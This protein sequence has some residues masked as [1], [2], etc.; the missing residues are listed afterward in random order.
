MRR[1]IRFRVIAVAACL[2]SAAVFLAPGVSGASGRTDESRGHR[3]HHQRAYFS[4]GDSVPFG[5]SPLLEDPWIPERFVGYP[6]II[7]KHTRLKTTNFACPGQTAQA[8]V[9][10][11]ALD[12]GCFDARDFFRGEGLPF[13][14]TDYDATQVDAAIDALHSGVRPALISVQGGGGEF[15]LCGD[16]AEEPGDFEACLADQLPKVTDSLVQVVRSLR[17]AGYH[18]RVVLVGYY[19][20]PGLPDALADLDVAIERAA[21]RTHV[22]FADVAALFTRYADRHHGDTCTTGLLVAFDDGECDIH[23]SQIGHR[24]IARAV[25]EAAAH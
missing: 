13:L 23:P 21:R 3:G 1:S 14:H 22:A 19:P 4:L 12:N 8:L 24:L 10:L 6:E 18:G 11:D 9:S 7:G 25:L 5:Y 16:A 20:V 15:V 2:A 17:A